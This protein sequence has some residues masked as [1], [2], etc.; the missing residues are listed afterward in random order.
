M[1]SPQEEA[2][3]IIQSFRINTTNFLKHRKTLI[4]ILKV[5]SA[6]INHIR[7]MNL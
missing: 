4:S 6:K 2:Y 5:K 7:S 1:K 3:I